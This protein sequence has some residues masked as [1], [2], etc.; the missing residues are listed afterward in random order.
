MTSQDPPQEDQ[1]Y[2]MEPPADA[3]APPPPPPQTQPAAYPPTQPA[4]AQFR[5]VADDPAMRWLLPVGRSGLAIAAGYMGLFAVLLI[6]APF[7]LI[8]GIAAVIHL[9]RRPHLRGM[10]RA[11]FAIVMGALFSALLVFIVVAG[12]LSEFGVA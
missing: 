5:D 7:A 10:G 6:F 3:P 2:S 9:K 4:P 12:V 8:L 1:G 11:V